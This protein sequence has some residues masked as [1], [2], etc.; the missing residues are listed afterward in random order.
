MGNNDC[1][2]YIHVL[3]CNPERNELEIAM[4]VV[5]I[6]EIVVFMLVDAFLMWCLL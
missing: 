5:V 3:L 6:I 4:K 1:F 2:L